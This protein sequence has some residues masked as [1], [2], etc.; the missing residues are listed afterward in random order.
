MT[1]IAMAE[2][3]R[4]H[5]TLS[6]APE[7]LRGS[8]AVPMPTRREGRPLGGKRPL[9]RVRGDQ[10]P[11]N[12]RYRDDGCNIH[13]QCL[14]CPLPQCRYEDRGGLRGM[15][16][17]HRDREIVALRMKGVGAAEVASRFGIS[18]RTVFRVLE[19][20]ARKR[21]A[22]GQVPVPVFLR[23]DQDEEEARCA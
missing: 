17:A 6:A 12:M 20:E 1:T 16:N 14:T 15:M 18:R 13:P 3:R 21:R 2:T 11:E 19:L 5:L 8:L 7:G 4:R 23:R 10:L 9:P 22:A